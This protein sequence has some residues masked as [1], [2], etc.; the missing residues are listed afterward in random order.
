MESSVGNTNARPKTPTQTFQT[1]R[2]ST[3]PKKSPVSPSSISKSPR[4]PR[5]PAWSPQQQRHVFLDHLRK[6]SADHDSSPYFN[7]KIS[8][9]QQAENV[10]IIELGKSIKCILTD[11]A[12]TDARKQIVV[13]LFPPSAQNTKYK[14]VI[15]YGAG[16]VSAR[17]FFNK[18]YFS[19]PQLERMHKKVADPPGASPSKGA[20]HLAKW[21]SSL[22]GPKPADKDS[23]AI[24]PLFRPFLKLPLELQQMILATAAGVTGRYRVERDRSHGSSRRRSSHRPAP[25]GPFS[26]ISLATMMKISKSLNGHL[27]PWV[28]RTTDFEFGTTGFTNFL[29][30]SGPQRRAELKN[31][32]FKFC[33]SGL[34]HC[35]RW[36]AADPILELFEPPVITNPPALRYF[37]RCQ[38]QDLAKEV[39][40]S[41]LTIDICGVPF[42]DIAMMVRI[43]RQA[44]GSIERIRF[45]HGSVIIYKD[46]PRLAGT[47]AERTWRQ[48]CRGFIE[49]RRHDRSSWPGMSSTVSDMKGEDVEQMMDGNKEFFDRVECAWEI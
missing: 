29:W 22:L 23:V 17:E 36:L 1:T 48:E 41:T 34:A 8:L 12:W 43:L 49:R 30:M 32:T 14:L 11:A 18:E 37:W 47:T 13:R 20:D 26:P 3:T 46:N 6:W 4:S 42:P 2:N 25:T 5:K 31:L 39:H 9:L 44:F 28:Y 21:R 40:L 45:K 24:Q 15:R 19:Y 16:W 27:V 35:I 7:G 38:I 33:D 10:E